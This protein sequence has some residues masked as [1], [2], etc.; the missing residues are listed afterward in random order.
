MISYHDLTVALCEYKINIFQYDAYVR[1]VVF[2]HLD[3]AQK[4]L[5]AQIASGDLAG[6]SKRELD[7]LVRS[8]KQIIVNE[9]ERIAVYL[10][11]TNQDF[12]M[13][14]HQIE[15]AIYNDWLGFKA[16]SSM[17]NYKLE[18]VKYAPLF[19]GRD[20]GDWWKKQSNDLQFKIES[21][22]RDAS[23]IETSSAKIS[24]RIRDEIGISKVHADTLIR[25]ANAAIAND[26]QE[27]LIS[28]NSDIVEAKQH[29]ST[30]DNRTTDICKVRDL[31]KWTLD[32]KPIGHK[33]QYRKPPLHFRCRSIIRMVIKDAIASTRSSQFGQVNDS[34]DYVGWLKS[35]PIDYQNSVLGAKRAKWFREGKL[36]MSQMLDQSDRPLTIKQ[37]QKI[38]NL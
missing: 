3:D 26:A 27:K 13:A 19:E 29:V 23:V 38:Y 1:S 11:A 35:Q 28:Y 18:S 16:F 2:K 4:A 37:L 15:A 10:A 12:Y 6:I 30:L 7:R 33:M 14:T 8:A 24:K 21:I 31:K 5:I 34:L 22:I 9:Y 36:T 25:T 17:P 32:N 20:I